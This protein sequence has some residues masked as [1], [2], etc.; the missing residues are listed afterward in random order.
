MK[1]K[2]KNYISQKE[3]TKK[4]QAKKVYYDHVDGDTKDDYPYYE[5]SSPTDDDVDDDDNNDNK[6]K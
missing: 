3:I 2:I 5:P 6:N 1:P 4:Q